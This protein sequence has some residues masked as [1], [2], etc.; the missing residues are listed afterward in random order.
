MNKYLHIVVD[1]QF[2]IS[3]THQQ[4]GFFF[5]STHFEAL[6]FI[7]GNLYGLLSNLTKL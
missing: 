5:V 3:L 1:A 7:L 4:A 6:R 2:R